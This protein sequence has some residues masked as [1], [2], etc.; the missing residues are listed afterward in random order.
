MITAPVV[1]T[2]P[3]H[4]WNKKHKA[5]KRGTQGASKKCE[6]SGSCYEISDF[7]RVT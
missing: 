4:G 5:R 3:S 7:V 6:N 2:M 1:A